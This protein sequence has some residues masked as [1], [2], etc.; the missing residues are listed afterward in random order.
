M[1]KTAITI[2]A[3]ACYLV[4]AHFALL[5]LL[6]FIWGSAMSTTNSA[7]TRAVEA[8]LNA[9]ITATAPAVNFVANGGTVGGSVTISGT[10]TVTGNQTVQGTSFANGDEH[11]GGTLY[12]SGGSLA[13]GD[14]TT[15]NNNLAVTGTMYGSSGPGGPLHVDA[16]TTVDTLNIS[17]GAFFISGNGITRQT[18]PTKISG[19]GTLSSLTN[20]VNAIIGQL[21]NSG[22]FY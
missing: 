10:H 9:H 1:R 18:S 7:K 22:W 13:I 8:R 12:G 17:A 20:A 5:A 16:A 3:L 4:P 6:V 21:Q 2:A 15:V 19:T 14:A 11:I